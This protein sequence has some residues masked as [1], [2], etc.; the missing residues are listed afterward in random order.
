MFA[1]YKKRFKRCLI[2]ILAVLTAFVILISSSFT[3]SALDEQ[4]FY[5]TIAQPTVSPQ[6]AYVEVL[7]N[8]GSGDRVEVV[9]FS[10]TSS[11][12]MYLTVTPYSVIVKNR[13]ESDN[14]LSAFWLSTSGSGG[15]INAYENSIE[16]GGYVNIKGIRTYGFANV[17]FT[18]SMTL[19][20]DFNIV[21]GEQ[22]IAY[23]QLDTIQSLL[24]SIL[25]STSTSTAISNQTARLEQ[26]QK[27]ATDNII[28]NQQEQTDKILNG[29]HDTPQY[30]D[31]ESNSTI[32]ETEEKEQQAQDNANHGVDRYNELGNT[33]G[34]LFNNDSNI[35]NGVS[36]MSYVV[37]QVI[38][39]SW[40]NSL[41]IIAL[42]IGLFAFVVNA[43]SM[44]VKFAHQRSKNK[45]P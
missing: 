12:G 27:E 23:E 15:F 17:S 45:N 25:N 18:T 8:G 28:Q 11:D 39:E 3:V 37:G 20:N 13:I 30:D 10:S 1:K 22:Q 41:L 5:L 32:T 33:I 43:V 7:Y 19:N 2:S 42:Y 34:N 35:F 31:Y 36:A 40:V 4:L 26:A 21:Y 24:R 16:E 44:V 14:A 9:M 6:N 38:G 29:G